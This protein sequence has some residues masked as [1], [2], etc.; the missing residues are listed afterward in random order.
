LAQ[1]KPI[2]GLTLPEVV[3]SDWWLAGAI[4]C[5]NGQ[6]LSVRHNV[7]VAVPVEVTRGEARSSIDA[8]C[9]VRPNGLKAIVAGGF[10]HDPVTIIVTHK[11]ICSTV[12]IK[13]FHDS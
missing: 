10:V 7:W 1:Q 11:D 5:Q 2:I 3:H 12:S 6:V 13:I 9:L 8:I 4:G